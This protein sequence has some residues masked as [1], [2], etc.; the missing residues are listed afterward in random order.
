M[1]IKDLTLSDYDLV[2]DINLVSIVV[3]KTIHNSDFGHSSII[4]TG[5][6]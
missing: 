2:G 1:V 6:R 4:L 3:S 5:Q